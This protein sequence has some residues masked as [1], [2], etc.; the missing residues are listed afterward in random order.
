MFFFIVT[1]H[2][3]TGHGDAATPFLI[4]KYFE[5]AVEAV[6]QAKDL[7]YEFRGMD[8]GISIS[9]MEAERSYSKNDFK[10]QDGRPV[11]VDFPNI[12]FFRKA[13]DGFRVEYHVSLLARLDLQLPAKWLERAMPIP[14]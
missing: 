3:A 9:H 11:P 13:Q 8:H 14:E 2:H 12:L 7:G 10:S 1:A 6:D 5:S 4:T